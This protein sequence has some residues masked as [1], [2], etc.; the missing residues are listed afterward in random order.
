MA[1]AADLI[2]AYHSYFN[3]AYRN[4]IS[5]ISN[6]IES[7]RRQWRDLS[8]N[9]LNAVTAKQAL[10]LQYAQLINTDAFTALVTRLN[11][12][13][14]STNETSLVDLSTQISQQVNQAFNTKERK[15]HE[16]VQLINFS[17]LCENHA[18]YQR[19]LSSIPETIDSI[20]EAI[21]LFKEPYRD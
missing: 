5:D 10:L 20:R 9:S 21:R 11:E 3:E 7:L 2:N 19:N 1:T 13:I 15:P 8:Y 18:N 17:N 4:Y 16:I 12:F 14:A 6:T